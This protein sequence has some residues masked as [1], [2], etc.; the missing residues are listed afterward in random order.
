MQFVK[1]KTIK[2]VDRIILEENNCESYIYLILKDIACELFTSST[3][4]VNFSYKKTKMDV[5]TR[6]SKKSDHKNYFVLLHIINPYT[7]ILLHEL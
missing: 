6:S 1:K 5:S 4:W 3:S 2:E 7:F